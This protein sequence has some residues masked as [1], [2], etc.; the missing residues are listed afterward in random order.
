MS[1]PPPEA[2]R[3]EKALPS[4]R[5]KSK[6]GREMNHEDLKDFLKTP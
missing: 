2:V 6:A 5:L 4:C 3:F 1:Q